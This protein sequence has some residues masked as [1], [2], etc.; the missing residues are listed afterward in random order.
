MTGALKEFLSLASHCV[1]NAEIPFETVAFPS[2][3]D[4]LEALKRGEIDCVFP[5][6][7]SV[8]DA[9]EMDLLTTIPLMQ[10]EMYAVVRSAGLRDFTMDGE[11]RVAVNEGNPSYEAF[12]ME[13]FP[14]WERAL[15]PDTAACLKAV[16]ERKADCI[17]VGNYRINSIADLLEKYKLSTV[18]TGVG[19]NSYFVLDR[20][21]SELYAVLNKVI[22]LV[23][24]S[25]VNA[26][27]ASYSY[28]EQQITFAR[29]IRENSAAVLGG[30]GV[31]LAVILALLLQSMRSEKKTREAMG[32]IAE[33]NEEQKTQLDEIARLNTELSD[34]QQKLKEALDTSEQASR[35]KTSFL[36]NMSHEIRTPMNAIIGLDNIA[37]RDPDLS[38]HTRDQLEKIGAS[39]KHLLGIINDILDMSRIESGRMALK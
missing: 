30:L 36:S 26:A 33:L 17:L 2:T 32:R 23:P 19:M 28:G 8:Y 22:N 11:V 35:A 5:V 20:Q 7:F 38:A 14:D 1:R 24:T 13:H 39:A 31:I 21:D 29:F 4:A 15:F 12:L 16:A 10:C 27:L 18:T 37:L 9:E 3:A 6:N 25:A 34:N